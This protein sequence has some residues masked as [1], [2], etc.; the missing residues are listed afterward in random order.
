MTGGDNAWKFET[1]DQCAWMRLWGAELVGTEQC[2]RARG[3]PRARD[4]SAF[5]FLPWFETPSIFAD[6]QLQSPNC[7][8]VGRW[9]NNLGT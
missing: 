8:L 3:L 1:L 5:A 9:N 4:L 6:E 7:L 2:C